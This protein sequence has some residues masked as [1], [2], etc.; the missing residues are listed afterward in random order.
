MLKNTQNLLDIMARLRHPEQGCPWDLRQDF[1]TLIPYLIEEAYE[2][3]DAI[4]RNDMD[5]LRSELGDLLL[6][7]VFHSQLANE[8]GL[9]NFEQVAE[10]ICDKLIR[11]H[12]HVFSDVVFETDA[13]RQQAW[14]Q[15]KA[16]ERQAKET[17]AKPVS[18]LAGVAG[19]LPAL[20]ECEKIQDRAAQHGFDWPDTAPVFDKVMEELE[21]VWE[22]WQSGDHHH[23]REEIGDLLLVVVNLARHLEV[24]AEQALK[25]STKKFSRR[26]NYIERQV[27]SSGRNLTDCDLYELDAFWHEAKQV[28][29]RKAD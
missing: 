21:E 19:S 26:F 24:N 11:R 25:E 6:Q 20:L 2:V 23:I 17:S 9:F 1:A 22:A 18:V 7:V 29:K 12:P 4:E 27:A 8:R 10:S 28:L 16:D 14:E 5:D 13:E 3:V 15:A